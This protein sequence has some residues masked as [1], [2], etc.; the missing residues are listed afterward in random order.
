MNFAALAAMPRRT[1]P[2]MSRRQFGRAMAGS[3][4]L[5]GAFGA[6]LMRPSPATAASFAP[7]PIPGGTPL[8]GGAFH[9]FGPAAIDPIDAEPSTITHMNGF[10]GLA[11]INGNVTR[12]N[13]STGQSDKL[14]F[15]FTDMRFMTGEFR[16]LD[17]R[18]H[19]GTFAL[20]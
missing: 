1:P 14:P 8:L 7:V 20:V 9:F 15:L 2:R 11:Y 10:V 19:R 4:V 17:G 3:A 5:G 12:T 16:G 18:V 13:L 6:G